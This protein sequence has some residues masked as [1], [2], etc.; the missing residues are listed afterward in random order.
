M[1]IHIYL[2]N[3]DSY[4]SKEESPADPINHNSV[5][6]EICRDITI[7]YGPNWWLEENRETGYSASY[8]IHDQFISKNKL[9]ALCV[10]KM[11][12]NWVG[13]LYLDSEKVNIVK[14]KIYRNISE[15]P[16]CPAIW[17]LLIA[18]CV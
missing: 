18:T 7:H 10:E 15:I 13:E 3:I 8:K 17:E 9:R 12:Q 16:S 14:R 5:Q 6:N 1:E 4:N 2:S 11:P